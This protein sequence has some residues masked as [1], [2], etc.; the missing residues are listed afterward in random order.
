[1]IVYRCN[2]D[3]ELSYHTGGLNHESVSVVWQGQLND[4]L[5]HYKEPS[6]YQLELAE[7]F[8]PWVVQH[9]GFTKKDQVSFHSEAGEFGGRAKAICP[10]RGV[11]AIVTEFRNDFFED[12]NLP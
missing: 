2:R 12:W 8:Y 9:Y 10:G 4:Q 1:M 3:E 7:A 5:P 6:P 11:E